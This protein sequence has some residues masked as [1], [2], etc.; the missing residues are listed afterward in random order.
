VTIPS[1][2]ATTLSTAPW[3][4]CAILDAVEAAIDGGW[5]NE[6]EEILDRRD[7]AE[8]AADRSFWLPAPHV[9]ETRRVRYGAGGFY[10][11][12]EATRC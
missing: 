2:L 1:T 7:Q 3:G 8:Q 11:R 4:S 12:M 10:G 9:G 6:A 5:A